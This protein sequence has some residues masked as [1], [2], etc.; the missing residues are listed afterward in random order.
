[1]L[2]DPY[3]YARGSAAGALGRLG[4]TRAVPALQR[5]LTDD[6]PVVSIY[7]P[8]IHHVAAAAIAEIFAARGHTRPPA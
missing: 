4:D 8:S 3:P 5:L 7:G 1:M 6:T 2:K